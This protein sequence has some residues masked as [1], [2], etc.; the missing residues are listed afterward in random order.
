MRDVEI[1]VEVTDACSDLELTCEITSNEPDD[2][3]G[4]GES[5]GDVNGQDGYATPVEVELLYD[6]ETACFT[7]TVQ[8]RAE[9]DGSETSRVYS[10][11]CEVSDLAGNTSMASCVVVV[12]H[13]R[14]RQ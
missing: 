14:R 3:S 13:D 12:P 8:L 11:C 9:R 4:D 5:I 1:R 7:G 10:I 6:P 2:A